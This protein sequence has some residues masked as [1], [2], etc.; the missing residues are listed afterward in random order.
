MSAVFSLPL[1]SLC[2]MPFGLRFSGPAARPFMSTWRGISA[3]CCAALS[4]GAFAQAVGRP[5]LWE[6]G[7]IALGVSQQAYP[8]SDQQV[9]RAVPLPYFIYRG[10]VL[11]ADRETAG[12]RAMK[13]ETFEIDVGFAGAF[14]AGGDTIDARKGMRT[15]G[16][17][18]ELGPR[19]KWNLRAGPVGGRLSAEFP[20][21]AVLDLSDK[22]AH[23]G[24]SFEPKLAYAGRSDSGWRYSASVSA[25]VA[26]TGLAQTF[27]EVASSEATSQRPAY[28]AKRGLVAWRVGTTASRSLGRDWNLFGFARLDSVAGAANDSSPLVRRTTGA[29]VGMGL[30]YTWLRSERVAFD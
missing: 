20:I 28:S 11:R 29:T 16:T 25:I 19:L 30:T 21:R 24:W 7:G 12:I 6:L 3:A 9:N 23:R 8:G 22:A 27:Y 15:L 4:T 26:D 13:T 1:G 17:L 14:G 18:V 2:N 10:D 5:P